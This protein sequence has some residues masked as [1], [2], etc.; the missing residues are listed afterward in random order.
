[1]LMISVCLFCASLARGSGQQHYSHEEGRRE[2]SE[3]GRRRRELLESLLALELSTDVGA[4]GE[5]AGVGLGC[6]MLGA[7]ARLPPLA[8]GPLGARGLQGRDHGGRVEAE[9]GV[10]SNG[11]KQPLEG[12][13]KRVGVVV[14]PPVSGWLARPLSLPHRS[15]IANGD[16]STPPLR[17]IFAR[18][19]ALTSLHHARKPS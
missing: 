9:A 15:P 17:A 19:H 18:Y 2:A 10:S 16:A 12:V 1:M 3:V 4:M 7:A 14:D 5:C 11:T 8:A 13:H 6:E